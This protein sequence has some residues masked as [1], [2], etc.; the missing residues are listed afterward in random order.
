MKPAKTRFPRVFV[1]VVLI[2]IVAS[3]GQAQEW[4]FSFDATGNLI[5][6]TVGISSPPQI[7]GQP[8]N[9]VI[10]PGESAS[11]SVVAAD[12]RALT[13]QWRFNEEDITG[14]TNETL[15]LT[16]V[17]ATN[18]GQYSVVL[19]NPSGSVTSAPAALMLD[20]DGDGLGDSWEQAYFGSLAQYSTGDFDGDGGS[21]LTEFQ[22]GTVPTNS[23]SA[24]FRLTLLTDGGEV[25]VA[26]SRFKFTNGETVTL[27]ATAFS[28]HAFHA[29]GGDIDE[30]NNP[31]T[32]TITSNTTVFAYLSS[33]DIQ[34]GDGVS[35][36]WHNRANWSPRFVPAS[37]DHVIIPNGQVTNTSAVA[38]RRLTLGGPSSAPTLSGSGTLAVLERCDWLGGTFAGTGGTIVEPGATL[39]AAGGTLRLARGTLENHGTVLWT[40][41]NLLFDSSVISNR[42][43]A[44]FDARGA[45]SLMGVAGNPRFHNEGT[46]RKSASAGT[47]SADLAFNNYNTVEIEAGTFVCTRGLLNNGAIH[48]APGATVR[49]GNGSADGFFDVSSTSVMEWNGAFTLRPGAQ[50]NGV[51]LYRINNGRLSLNTAVAVNNLDLLAGTLSGSGALTISNEMNWTSGTMDG[52]GRTIIAAGATLNLNNPNGVSLYERTLENAGTSLWA[53]A[54]IAMSAAVITNRSLFHAQNAAPIRIGLLAGNRF[55]NAGT[56]RKSGHSGTT[57]FSAN[58]DLHNY[59]TVEIQTGTFVCANFVNHGTVN[60]APG[61]TQRITGVGSARGTFN[62]PATALLDWNFSQ[63]TLQPGA[64]LNGDGLYQVTGGG[65][66][67]LTCN[68]NISVAN[69]DL[70]AYLSGPG[71]LTVGNAMNWTSGTMDRGGRT[72]IAPGATLNISNPAAVSLQTRTLENGGTTLWTGANISFNTAVITNRAGAL[73]HAQNAA[74]MTFNFGAN[75]FDNAGTFRKSLDTGTTTLQGGIAFHNHHTVEIR[76]GILAANGGYTATSNAWLHCTLG[77]TTAGTGFGQLRI[78]GAVTVN[79]SLR[80]DFTSGFVPAINDAFPVLTAGTRSGTFAGFLQPANGVT[81]ELSN[82][83]TSV[84]VRVNDLITNVPA[85]ILLPPEISGSNVTLVWTA[86]A[87]LTYRLEF[88]PD[89]N[90]TN[91]ESLPGDVTSTSNTASKAD[92]ITPSNR[93]YR[94]RLSP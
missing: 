7:L 37:N 89:L 77:G 44:L 41:G 84:I 92:V 57:T 82:T 93:F 36:N 73:F 5:V 58:V 86:M 6:H 17:G 75:R 63:F 26:P 85:P 2:L 67:R 76:N 62:V 47:V 15:L 16:N 64:Q 88:K 46:F 55:D 18:E 31:I 1:A 19:V 87:N 49:A 74:S 69:L 71:A 72:I 94:V 29:W 13:Y 10:A 23:A 28:P 59:D 81:M 9:Q 83:P 35:G 42:A 56:F 51:G 4:Q 61:T 91:W 30:P 79:G 66:G 52:G 38:C 65:G 14:A 45:G 34:W 20:S 24:I 11:F 78:A 40:M 39:T 80:V 21:N 68:T 48:L 22:D 43:G 25:T 8:Q 70:M 54:D 33:Y 60:L 90:S 32:L 3:S 27:T 12:S 53:G 50:L